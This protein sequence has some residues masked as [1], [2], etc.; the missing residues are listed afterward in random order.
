MAYHPIY[1]GA[2]DITLDGLSEVLTEVVKRKMMVTGYVEDGPAGGNPEI[3]IRGTRN[4]FIAWMREFYDP[5]EESIGSDDGVSYTDDGAWHA[6]QE[7]G[8]F[9]FVA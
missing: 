1:D 9:K 7:M 5:N 2:F 4:Q 6:Y 3:T 8:F